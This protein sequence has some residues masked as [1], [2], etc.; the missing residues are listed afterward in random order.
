VIPDLQDL[1]KQNQ[2]QRH[3]QLKQKEPSPY[4]P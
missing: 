3:T 1:H 4:A 2:T